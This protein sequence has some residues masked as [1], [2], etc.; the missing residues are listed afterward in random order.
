M[1]FRTLLTNIALIAGLA[2][3]Q[4]ADVDRRRYGALANEAL[5]LGWEW[6]AWPGWSPVET[7]TVIPEWSVSA[8]YADAATIWYPPDGQFY[9][10]NAPVAAGEAPPPD[11]AKWGVTTAPETKDLGK[12]FGVYKDDPRYKP[13]AIRLAFTATPDGLVVPEV[14]NGG[15][16]WIHYRYSTPRL[17]GEAWDVARAYVAG[18]L[19]YD[20]ASG[21]CYLCLAAN[22]GAP[23][24]A[25]PDKWRVQSIPDILGDYV[26][27]ATQANL[28]RSQGQ[29]EQAGRTEGGARAALAAEYSKA[30]RQT[31]ALRP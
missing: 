13:R 29:Y 7:I 24:L 15:T 14:A 20:D 9:L 1:T 26:R 28:L 3:E 18:D 8:A 23:P 4:L 10:S 5:R 25:N 17:T 30:M 2:P 11:N 12:V 22:T 21:D 16:V 31:S 27:D 19:V 6:G